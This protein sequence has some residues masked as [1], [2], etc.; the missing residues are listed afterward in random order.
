MRGVFTDVTCTDSD[1]SA[2][3]VVETA[4]VARQTSAEAGGSTPPSPS[5]SA[6]TLSLAQVKIDISP[7]EP[8]RKPSIPPR[9]HNVR[10]Q[11]RKD[12]HVGPPPPVHRKANARLSQKS[13]STKKR[14]RGVSTSVLISLLCDHLTSQYQLLSDNTA[15]NVTAGT[16]PLDEQAQDEQAQDEQAPDKRPVS[17]SPKYSFTEI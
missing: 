17:G 3:V 16:A 2:G 5:C 1:P 10:Q 13:K 7:S 6:L 15:D 8:G 12:Y 11:V 9:L 14:T 4:A